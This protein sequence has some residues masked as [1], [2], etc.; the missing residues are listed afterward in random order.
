MMYS[1]QV[2]EDYS[3]QFNQIDALSPTSTVLA[4]TSGTS[5]WTG[6]VMQDLL[7]GCHGEYLRRGRD[8]LRSVL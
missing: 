7:I 8:C 2:Q 4:A 5:K 1:N 6:L 3:S